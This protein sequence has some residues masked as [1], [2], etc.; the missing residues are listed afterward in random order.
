MITENFLELVDIED[1]IHTEEYVNMVDISV[2]VDQSFLL[3]NGLISHNSAGQPMRSYRNQNQGFFCLRGK[4]MNV[5][6]I[7]PKKVIENK[8][9]F[10]LMQAIGL[11]WKEKANIKNIRYSK[12]IIATDADVDG[13]S[14]TGQLLNFFSNWP[15]LFEWGMIYRNITPLLIV[16]DKKAKKEIYFYSQNSFEEFAS[17]SFNEKL[18]TVHYKKGI[19]SLEAHQFKKIISDPILHKYSLTETCMEKLNVWFGK[20]ADLRKNELIK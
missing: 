8:E 3:S 9:T 14:I 13:D 5:S 11:K 1:I 15:E 7:D 10:G 4:F 17:K 20:D 12:I 6:E 16:E 19:G 18:H 2:E